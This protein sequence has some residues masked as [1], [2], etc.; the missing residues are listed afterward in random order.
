[1][2]DLVILR[3]DDQVET[4]LGELPGQLEADATGGAGDKRKGPIS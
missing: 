1:M 3:G 2:L 4:V